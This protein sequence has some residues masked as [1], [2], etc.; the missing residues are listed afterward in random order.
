ME[1]TIRD[2][3][4][5]FAWARPRLRRWVFSGLA[6]ALVWPAGM[7][8]DGFG[9]DREERP[10]PAAVVTMVTDGKELARAGAL[11]TAPVGRVG[12]AAGDA[13]VGA[14]DVARIERL[15]RRIEPVLGTFATGAWSA[16]VVLYETQ[17]GYRSAASRSFAPTMVETAVQQT[18]GFTTGTTVFLP[19]YKYTEDAFLAN[20]LAHELT[21]AVVNQMGIRGGLPSWLDEGF[22]WSNGFAAQT[23]ID[24][25]SVEPVRAALQNQLEAARAQGRWRP[26]R[27]DPTA[28]LAS[29]LSYNLEY[30]DYLAFEPL[31]AQ[32]G[33]AAF[34]RFLRLAAGE[35]MA[36]AFRQVYG[37]SPEAYL[38]GWNAAFNPAGA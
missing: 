32:G 29:S 6:F 28:P 1:P 31:L 37:Q 12:V 35:E 34:A 19:L 4:P 5:C 2:G 11:S 25:D 10:Q 21:H 23:L 33:Q 36:R 18:G 20:T 13:G 14:G 16:T 17:D 7:A 27:D 30:E 24:P 3:V 38:Q 15:L 8:V 9:R 22:A 26:I